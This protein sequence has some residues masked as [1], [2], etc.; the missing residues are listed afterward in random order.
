MLI[1]KTKI[2]L[3]FLPIETKKCHGD[4]GTKN[5]NNDTSVTHGIEGM[6]AWAFEKKKKKNAKRKLLQTQ[7]SCR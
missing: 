4:S 6:W 3:N 1:W 7:H 2:W 5:E